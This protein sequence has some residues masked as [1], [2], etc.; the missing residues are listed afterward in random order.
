MNKIVAISPFAVSELSGHSI[1]DDKYYFEF[2]STCSHHV[3]FYTSKYSADRLKTTLS[4]HKICVIAVTQSDGSLLSD[5]QFM[6]TIETT[7]G[8]VVVF[9]GY[10]ERLVLIHSVLNFA[11]RYQLVLIA[12]NNISARRVKK[13]KLALKAF[14]FVIKPKIKR[15]VVHSIAEVDLLSKIIS[16]VKPYC[17][18]KRT[19]LM[20]E[21]KS[22]VRQL[23][24][25]KLVISFFGPVKAEKP[26]EPLL[27]LIKFSKSIDCLINIY[28]VDIKLILKKLQ[29]DHLPQ[30]VFLKNDWMDESKYN[31][32]VEQTDLILLTHNRDFEG[33][34]SGN[35]CDCIAYAKPFISDL[36]EPAISM[37]QNNERI[38]LFYDFNSKYWVTQ[39][40]Q[41]L[42]VKG[43]AQMRHAIEKIRD[44]EFS[45]DKIHSDMLFVVNGVK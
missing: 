34:L 42:T 32:A 21:R 16:W 9:L 11:N 22:S 37:A 38:G 20:L 31:E 44:R 30:N 39:L 26:I 36:I 2:L 5:I 15:L 17:F 4:D 35:L 13:Y 24:S 27:D 33:K 8:A 45:Q 1:L 23:E 28:K 12:T 3:E 14:F 25:S 43:V 18:V 41:D 19:H 6:R 40:S 7:S 29:T 10:T